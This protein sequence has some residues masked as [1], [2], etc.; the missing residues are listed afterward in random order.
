MYICPECKKEFKT[1]AVVVKHMS[2]CW[3][4]K[5]PYHKSKPAPH[6]TD[7]KR[8]VSDNVLLFFNELQKEAINGRKNG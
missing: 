4:E 2:S 6:T 3:R 5:H 7:T 8:E 1:E